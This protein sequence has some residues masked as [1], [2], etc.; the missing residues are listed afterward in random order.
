MSMGIRL[1][2]VK[3]GAREKEEEYVVYIAKSS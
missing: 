1:V 3:V 2:A